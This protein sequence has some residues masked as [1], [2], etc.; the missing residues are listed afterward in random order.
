MVTAARIRRKTEPKRCR[1]VMAKQR[2]LVRD[3][4]ALW[5][6]VPTEQERGILDGP[7]EP[8]VHDLFQSQEL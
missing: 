1:N 6:H 7:V 2:M 3:D 8:F 4:F 5:Y